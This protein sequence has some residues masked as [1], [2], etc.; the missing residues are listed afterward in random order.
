MSLLLILA[1]G[2]RLSKRKLFW[3]QDGCSQLTRELIIT[4]AGS[5]L[6]CFNSNPQLLRQQFL[7]KSS[8]L[9]EDFCFRSSSSGA[10]FVIFRVNANSSVQLSVLRAVLPNYILAMHVTCFLPGTFSITGNDISFIFH[11]S[12]RPVCLSVCLTV[13]KSHFFH[14][15]HTW[16]PRFINWILSLKRNSSFTTFDAKPKIIMA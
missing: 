3:G 11:N 5:R 9:S 12:S 2:V 6:W 15:R 8:F 4:R 10:S 14:N 1:S 7:V 13:Y 16:Y